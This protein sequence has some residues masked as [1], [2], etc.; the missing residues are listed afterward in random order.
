M[1]QTKDS[2]PRGNPPQHPLFPC[3]LLP[4]SPLSSALPWCPAVSG[5]PKTE[6]LFPR[7]A[8]CP[9]PSKLGSMASHSQTPTQGHVKSEWQSFRICPHRAQEPWQ[10]AGFFPLSLF[11]HAHCPAIHFKLI[12]CLRCELRV[13]IHFYILFSIV[14]ESIIYKHYFPPSFL[15]L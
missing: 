5:M 7:T 11:P 10:D 9:H 6:N 2:H 12:L 4:L 8:P 15:I 1:D 13:E 3:P 14:V